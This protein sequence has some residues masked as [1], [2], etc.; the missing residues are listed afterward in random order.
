MRRI[1]LFMG[2]LASYLIRG[3]QLLI[4]PLTPPSCRFFPTCSEYSRVSLIRHG[5]LKGLYLTL[6]RLFRCNPWNPGGWDPVPSLKDEEEDPPSLYFRPAHSR[7]G[8]DYDDIF[9]NN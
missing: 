2:R 8:R 3:Y 1:S 6:H 9:K 4:S 7:H 5:L